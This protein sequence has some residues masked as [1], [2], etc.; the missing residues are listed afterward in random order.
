[1][2]E[3]F[4]ELLV[5][6][7]QQGAVI[8]DEQGVILYANPFFQKTFS[9]DHPLEGI[10]FSDAVADQSLISAVDSV[11]SSKE[12][13]PIEVTIQGNGNQVLEVRFVPFSLNGLKGVIGF[14]QDVSEEKRVE[15]IKRDFVAN[16]SHEMRTPLASI[17]GYA[18]TLL[19]G[20]IED[21]E[22]LRNF[23]TIEI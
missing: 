5:K 16:V 21:K 18:E 6:E 22:V 10:K 13:Q 1:M 11:L 19:D 8:I 15:A 4:L 12:G 20:G 3:R 7:M 23:L 2:K 14:L 17:K 9:I